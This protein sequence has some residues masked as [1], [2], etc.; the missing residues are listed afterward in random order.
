M[1][2]LALVAMLLLAC[3]PTLGRLA[4]PSADGDGSSVWAALCTMTGLKYVEVPN[5]DPAPPPH[6]PLHG[7]DCAYCPLL[8]AV[9]VF[10]LWL[11]LAWPRLS[12]P[13]RSH[14]LPAPRPRSFHPCGLGS[15]GPPVAL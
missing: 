8:T 10:A 9:A 13:A 7:E 11:A 1:A 15:R 4:A 14:P 6:K 12:A 3:L 2:S 5:A